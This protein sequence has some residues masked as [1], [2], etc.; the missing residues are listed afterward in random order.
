MR[1][2]AQFELGGDGEVTR[3]VG[4]VSAGYEIE[5]DCRRAAGVDADVVLSHAFDLELDV[6]SH[7]E[8][9]ADHADARQVASDSRDGVLRALHEI[10]AC[11]DAD[12]AG[13]DDVDVF[14]EQWPLL[15]GGR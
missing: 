13:R 6:W 4:R 11:L 3:I 8:A 1:F 7:P 2:V 10:D 14:R 12:R 9:Y 15:R 5:R